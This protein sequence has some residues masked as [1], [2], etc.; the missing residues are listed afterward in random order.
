M[1]QFIKVVISVFCFAMCSIVINAQEISKQTKKAIEEV[2][3]LADKHPEDGKKQINAA[4]TL[5][6]EEDLERAEIY[7]NR[8]LNLAVKQPVPMDT[9]KGQSYNA[10]A[11][12]FFGKQRY[13]QSYDYYE[14]A[15]DAIEQEFGKG[16]PF[17]NIYKLVTG[18]W[19]T[20]MNPFRGFPKILEAF[21]YNSIESSEKRVE[22][23]DEASMILGVSFE[24]VLA[25]FIE[26]FR[27][28]LPE[29]NYNGGKCLVV[30]TRDWN[31]ERP[32]VGWFAPT[33][34]R[35]EEERNS[36]I[37]DE[38]IVLNEKGQFIIVP[39]DSL[40]LNFNIAIGR[41]NG[42]RLIIDES[43]TRLKYFT[44]S[45]HQHLL[46]KYREFKLERS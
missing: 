27:Y 28:A 42:C 22:N 12:I 17:T 44:P 21:Y 9:L 4:E 11:R 40:S 13:E 31:M 16:D 46:T 29:V 36:F 34:M 18:V 5:I 7:A 20:Q 30:Q 3:A 1:K 35:T 24:C 14:K 10:L 8:A 6:E 41:E 23:M 45:D 25:K 26:L 33:L 43:T 37:G 15:I 19:M 38:N 39:K 32:C 2:I